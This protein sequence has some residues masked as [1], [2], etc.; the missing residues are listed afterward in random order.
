MYPFFL[1]VLPAGIE[2]RILENYSEGS[3]NAGKVGYIAD[4]S[5]GTPQV[6]LN[7][8]QSAYV[9]WRYLEA[10]MPRKGDTVKVLRG[11][12]K[13]VV[14]VFKQSDQKQIVI[15]TGDKSDFIMVDKANV[16]KFFQ[17]N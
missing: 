14:G 15:Q 16:G 7:S 12:N 1:D 2:V 6:K 11:E 10:T 5:G 13:D 17:H 4:S 9:P 3:I 8:G